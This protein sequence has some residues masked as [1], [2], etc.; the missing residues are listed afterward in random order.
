VLFYSKVIFRD[1]NL[2]KQKLTKITSFVIIR[3]I[4]LNT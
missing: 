4:D 3:D 1:Y 2:K